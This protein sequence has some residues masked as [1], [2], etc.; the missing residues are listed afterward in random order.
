MKW[1]LDK[2]HQVKD[3]T[4]GVTQ[5]R[6]M[7]GISSSHP[8]PEDDPYAHVRF[9]DRQEKQKRNFKKILLFTV[10]AGVVAWFSNNFFGGVKKPDGPPIP[11]RYDYSLDRAR[12]DI[13]AVNCPTDKGHQALRHFDSLAEMHLST[14]AKS[15]VGD[16]VVRKVI[17]GQPFLCL[18]DLPGA[19]GMERRADG[20]LIV[21]KS[22]PDEP[23]T[24]TG[25]YAVMYETNLKRGTLAYDYSWSLAD[26]QNH[27]MSFEAAALLTELSVAH[28]KMAAGDSSMWQAMEKDPVTGPIA[29]IFDARVSGA[30]AAIRYNGDANE[31]MA[32]AARQALPEAQMTRGFAD[33]TNT[34]LL[35]AYA[36]ELVEGR[37]HGRSMETSREFA[38]AFGHLDNTFNATA[39]ARAAPS[40]ARFGGNREMAAA[41]KAVE[42]QRRLQSGKLDDGAKKVY[43]QEHRDN[44]FAKLDMGSVLKEWAATGYI[45]NLFD[46]MKD[47]AGLRPAPAAQPAPTAETSPA[48]KPATEPTPAPAT[49]SRDTA[50]R[51]SA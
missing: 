2:I 16:A 46:V 32:L 3:P 25:I 27:L 45:Q 10:L 28:Q 14:G 31:V 40:P 37:L 49:S 21:D 13:G 18:A 24:A 11:P 39:G 5:G 4:P 34:W 41:F 51:T 19:R 47:K 48:P 1:L 7:P 38:A 6:L 33:R 26:R 44:I 23:V 30:K 43:A 36:R 29:R 20:T 50:P 22:M 17:N 35:N 9:R 42:M 15:Y 12:A 8:P